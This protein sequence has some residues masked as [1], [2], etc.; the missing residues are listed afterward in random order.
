MLVGSDNIIPMG[1]VLDLTALGNQSEY[2]GDVRLSSGQD[3]P[4]SRAFAQGF[5]LSDDPYGSFSPTPWNGNQLY[6]PTVS[7][8]RLV[9][10]PTEIQGQVTQF[11]TN[12]GRLLPAKSVVTG[13]DF[14]SDAASQIQTTLTG[15]PLS[16]TNTSLISDTWN[17]RE[18]DHGA[19]HR[20][21]GDRAERPLRP[22]PA[23]GG[24]R[25]AS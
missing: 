18:P 12:N 19:Q 8:G 16:L 21:A 7:T 20:A 13:Y 11:L 5:V 22:L 23:A 15:A 3:N 25:H 2:K 4:I 24:R 1:R 17:T 10:T 9:E 14:T 6:L